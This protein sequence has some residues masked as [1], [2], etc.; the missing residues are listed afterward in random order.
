MAVIAFSALAVTDLAAADPGPKKDAGKFRFGAMCDEFQVAGGAA[1]VIHPTKPAPNGAKPWVWYA[2]T[3]GG[4]PGKPN[5][6]LFTRLLERGFFV[7]GLGVGETYANPRSREQYAE[8]YQHMTKQYGLAPKVCLLAQSRGG[9]NH[10]NFAADHPGWV[11]CIAGIYTVGD[12][13]SYPGLV[14]AAPAYG[15]TPAELEAQIARHTPVDRLVP[16]AAARIPIFHIHG[17]SDVL[18]PLE[19]NSG[20]IA[21]RYKA[22]GGHMELVIVPGEGH[23]V[24]PSFFESEKMLEFILKQGLQSP[25]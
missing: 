6:W 16:I 25:P 7:V 12:L 2:P 22:L 3:I 18:V 8:F 20:A 11:Q 14:K 15:L 13:R 1:F 4:N 23:K 5:E 21:E 19:K 10:Y 17:D 24:G 9:L